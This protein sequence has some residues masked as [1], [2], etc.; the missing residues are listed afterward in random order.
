MA[1]S[2]TAKELRKIEKHFV[3]L[4]NNMR[5]ADIDYTVQVSINSTDPK[6]VIYAAQLTAP[7]NGLAPIRILARSA[8]ELITKID[9][10]QKNIDEVAVEIAYH[11]AQIE[12]CERTKLG[13]E[14]RIAEIKAQ[15]EEEKE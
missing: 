6:V 5:R 9:V 2:E 11:E 14:E 1:T 8:E 10:A 7:A 12:A 4:R 13:H 3:K 15:Q